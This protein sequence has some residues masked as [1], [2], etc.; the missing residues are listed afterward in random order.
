MLVHMSV[1]HIFWIVNLFLTD[2]KVSRVMCSSIFYYSKKI[3][4]RNCI[5]LMIKLQASW[6]DQFFF[7]E[8]ILSA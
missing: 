7:N 6:G 2:K 3:D 5:K 8:I 1:I 4:Q